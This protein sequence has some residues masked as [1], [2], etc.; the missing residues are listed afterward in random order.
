GC[1]GGA[2]CSG[3]GFRRAARDPADA[4]GKVLVLPGNR[5]TTDAGAWVPGAVLP[6][7]KISDGFLDV[8]CA[9]GLS[10]PWH[11]PEPVSLQECLTPRGGIV[12][13]P[14]TTAGRAPG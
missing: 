12:S 11:C 4:F 9:L 8:A 13:T 1:G 5:S 7:R 6:G 10:A 2:W 14:L 3:R